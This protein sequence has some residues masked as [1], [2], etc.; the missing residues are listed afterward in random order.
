MYLNSGLPLKLVSRNFVLKA[1]RV[2]L[3]S[4]LLSVMLYVVS[5]SYESSLTYCRFS[6]ILNI[7]GKFVLDLAAESGYSV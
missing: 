5:S 1:S 7:T 4:L 3:S 2:R 6:S